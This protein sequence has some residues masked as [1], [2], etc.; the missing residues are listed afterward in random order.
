MQGLTW[1]HYR[2]EGKATVKGKNDEQ[3]RLLKFV[4]R[5]LLLSAD[6]LYATAVQPC[7]KKIQVIQI[8]LTMALFS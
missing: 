1:N 2:E 5:S 7:N 8:T 4:A 6:C 3:H